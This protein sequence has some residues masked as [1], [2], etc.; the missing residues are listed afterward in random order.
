MLSYANVETV[1]WPDRSTKWARPLFMTSVSA[2]FPSPAESYIEGHLDLN[3]YLI[4]H[5]VATFYVR[6]SGDSMAGAGIQPGSI[7]VVDRAVEADDGDIVIARI[8]DELCVKRLR[9]S[10]GRIWLMPENDRYQPIEVIES[11]D[12]EVWGRVMH[13]ISTF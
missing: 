4:K 10:R 7:L 3:R 11:M 8:G 9:L 5:P 13:A 1:M 12:F 6:V 2:G